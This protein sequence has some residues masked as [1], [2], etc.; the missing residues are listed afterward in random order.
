MKITAVEP[1]RA[2]T[3]LFAR[4]HTDAGITGIGECGTWGH[5]EAAEAALKKFARFLVGE[6]PMT[7]ERHWNVM[8]RANHYTGAAINGAISA[9]DMAFWDIKGKAH[10]VPVYDLLGGK[11]R[12]KV[13]LYAWVKGRSAAE[14]VE[15]SIA[16]VEQGYT[17]IGHLN[18]FLDD[19]ELIHYSAHAKMMELGVRLVQDVRNAIGTDVDI[20]LELHRR[21]TPPEAITLGRLLEPFTPLFY[22]DPI[23]PSSYDAMA[24]VADR[25]PLPIATGERFVNIQQFQALVSRRAAE[26]LRPSLGI[27]GGI[28]AG[29][30]IAAIAEGADVSIVPHNPVGPVGLAACLQLDAAIP[31]FAIQEYPIGTPGIDLNPG[32]SGTEMLKWFPEPEKGFLTIPSGPGL[33]VEFK[34]GFEERFPPREAS[35]EKIKMKA[36]FDGSVVDH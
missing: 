21:L 4:I 16:R 9:I 27:C 28:T 12:D 25:I 18:P 1:I 23:K 22:E 29:K 32:L 7:I 6:D 31:N 15:Q 19:A 14:F 5:Y 8:L 2:D 26:Y 35:K 33:G 13:R 3:F 17:A 36:H 10:G 30:K 20:C 24:V 11:M 34:P